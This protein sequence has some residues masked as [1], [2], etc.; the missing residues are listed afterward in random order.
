MRPDL[1]NRKKLSLENFL[2]ILL[3]LAF[4]PVKTHLFTKRVLL[5]LTKSFDNFNVAFHFKVSAKFL[6][7]VIFFK[8]LEVNSC[9]LKKFRIFESF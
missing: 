9:L 7:L 2:K 3:N 4:R 6:F 1:A 8:I 5:K